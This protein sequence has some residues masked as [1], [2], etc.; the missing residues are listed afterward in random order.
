MTCEASSAQNDLD[1]EILAILIHM[2]LAVLLADQLKLHAHTRH[3]NLVSMLDGEFR[4][5]QC[6]LC[7]CTCECG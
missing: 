1:D 3:L 7:A 4:V 2:Y 5:V 6:V